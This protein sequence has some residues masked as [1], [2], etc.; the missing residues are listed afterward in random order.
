MMSDQREA[1]EQGAPLEDPQ[2]SRT[3]H[4]YRG[5]DHAGSRL[6]QPALVHLDAMKSR[7]SPASAPH[8][9]A[10]DMAHTVALVESGVIAAT[11]GSAIL[12][13]LRRMEAEGLVDA[14][15]QTG[16]GVHSGEQYLTGLIG[17]ALAGQIA[18][19]RSSGDLYAVTRRLTFTEQIR[20]VLAGLLAVRR[21]LLALA[22]SHVETVMPGN[23]HGQHAQPT[24]LAHWASMFDIALA[25]DFDRLA[26]VHRRFNLSPAG[27]AIMTGSDFP[28]DRHRTAD[29]LGFDRPIA[30]TLDAILSHDIEIEYSAIMAVCLHSLARLADD[31]FLWSTFEYR[32]VELPDYLCGTSSIMPQKKNPDG[33]EDIKILAAQAAGVSTTVLMSER[34]P[35]GFPVLERNTTDAQLIALGE[36]MPARLAAIAQTIPDLKFDRDRMRALAGANWATATDLAAAIVRQAGIDW[37]SAHELVAAFVRHCCDRNMEPSRATAVDL[38]AV[39]AER[40]FESFRFT[41]ALLR[42]SLDPL[43]FVQR[44]ATFG[45]PKPEN[46]GIQLRAAAEELAVDDERLG[47]LNRQA[48]EA[49]QRLESAVDAVLAA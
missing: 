33:L 34:G 9:H 39:A 10:F 40:G 49:R 47:A 35:T 14:R 5:A 19:G 37:R 32:L 26:A 36:A 16:A 11:A 12:G 6:K 4:V 15:V 1:A 31:L 24:T 41:E 8:L 44:R 25:R 2:T 13:G 45:S 28:I 29:L 3:G 7:F 17:H 46:V 42:E 18:T 23:T 20:Q 38:A 21:A 22:G 48:D 27:A 43:A 30:N